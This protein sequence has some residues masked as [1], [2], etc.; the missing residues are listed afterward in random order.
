ME[1]KINRTTYRRLRKEADMAFAMNRYREASRILRKM[2]ADFPSLIST[3]DLRAYAFCLIEQNQWSR[4]LAVLQKWRKVEQ[5]SAILY[6]MLGHVLEKLGRLALAQKALTTSVSLEPR[7]SGYCLLGAIAVKRGKFSEA[8]SAFL[9]ALNCDPK[10][11]D[12][13][14]N[15]QWLARRCS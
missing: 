1:K 2:T 8:E 10:N 5:Q 14:E 13:I 4:A 15:L 11:S 9:D 7:A 12:A 3:A 6:A